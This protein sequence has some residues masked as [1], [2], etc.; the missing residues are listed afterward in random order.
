MSTRTLKATK[1]LDI[2]N[3]MGVKA[4]K[5][6]PQDTFSGEFAW[7]K[8]VHAKKKDGSNNPFKLVMFFVPIRNE[9]DIANLEIYRKGINKKS[10][11]ALKA[12]KQVEELYG[13]EKMF[14]NIFDLSIK[15]STRYA[16]SFSVIWNHAK[17]SNKIFSDFLD[18][19]AQLVQFMDVDSIDTFSDELDAVHN[20]YDD[21]TQLVE[22]VKNKEITKEEMEFNII[23]VA[24]ETLKLLQKPIFTATQHRGTVQLFKGL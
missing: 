23:D 24:H 20:M 18:R 14:Y 17:Q 5:H 8:T 11:D 9:D 16:D 4:I 10:G 3:I 2:L 21:Y 22:K 12:A 19:V 13:K 7:I 6:L 15:G 1:S